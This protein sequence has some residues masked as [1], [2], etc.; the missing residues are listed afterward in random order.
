MF[1]LFVYF[2]RTP[3]LICIFCKKYLLSS[4]RI[5]IVT[6]FHVIIV[7]IICKLLAPGSKKSPISPGVILTVGD[8]SLVHLVSSKQYTTAV[9]TC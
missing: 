9:I 8:N 7:V 3:I 4:S 2:C 5:F 1:V 6:C